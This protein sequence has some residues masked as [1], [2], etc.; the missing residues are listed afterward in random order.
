MVKIIDKIKDKSKAERLDIICDEAVKA[1]KMG[2][3]TKRGLEIDFKS[4]EKTANGGVVVYVSATKNGKSVGF[5]KDGTVEIEKITIIDPPYMVKDGTFHD[6][7]IDGKTLP[8]PNYVEDPEQALKD[9][10]AQTID[11][12]K[13]DGKNVIKDKVGTSTLVKYPDA[14]IEANTVDGSVANKNATWSTAQTADPATDVATDSVGN[15]A[16]RHGAGVRFAGSEWRVERNIILFDTSDIGATDTIDS[17]TITLET[18]AAAENDVS[19][20]NDNLILTQSA[21]ATDTAIVLGDYANVGNVAAP[22]TGMTAVALSTFNA[23]STDHTLTINATGLTWIARDGETITGGGGTAGITYFGL[24]TE[25]DVTA[26]PSGFVADDGNRV[27]FESADNAGGNT[28]APKLTVEYTAG[29]ATQ[30]SNFL[31]FL[32]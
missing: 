3:Y 25:D 4:I 20:G 21:P 23:A 18:T 7:I 19:T 2:K 16:A 31:P 26:T 32:M 8:S 24:R 11:G 5:G 13:K 17:A 1:A 27:L 15:L 22:T 14:H 29:G 9:D 30:N 10:I 28:V 6:I 12:I